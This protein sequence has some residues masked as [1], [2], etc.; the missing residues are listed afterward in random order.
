MPR[1]RSSG[2]SSITRRCRTGPCRNQAEETLEHRDLKEY[3]AA[4]AVSVGFRSELEEPHGGRTP[5][6]S[7]Y[8]SDL[9]ADQGPIMLAEVQRDLTD[10]ANL[11]QRTVDL[12]R[13]LNTFPKDGMFERTPAWYVPATTSVRDLSEDERARLYLSEDHHSVVD[14]VFAMVDTPTG[15]MFDLDGPPVAMT[16]TEEL[17]ARARGELTA[18]SLSGRSYA[19]GTPI[20]THWVTSL[21]GLGRGHRRPRRHRA[22]SGVAKECPR[23]LA[24][25]VQPCRY[26]QQPVL[27]VALE[28]GRC[29]KLDVKVTN[30]PFRRDSSRLCW[31][32]G[33]RGAYPLFTSG[34][35]RH[36]HREHRC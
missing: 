13:Y 9:T 11:D 18:I 4:C 1:T 21:P 20:F 24:G 19:S 30:G 17:Q 5:D 23:D 35:T 10:L 22:R 28:P 12:V 27:W 14:G 32:P 36:G 33:T 25:Y 7:I 26:C 34:A 6:V 31:S 2:R 8:R 29:V 15:T 16:V 3:I